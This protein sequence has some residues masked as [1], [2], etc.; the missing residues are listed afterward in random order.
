SGP[1][2][3]TR[4]ASRTG[5][6]KPSDRP[7]PRSI[8][9]GWR[10]ASI[11]ACP[12]TT[13]GRWWGSMIPPEPT[14]IREVAAAT[15]VMSTGGLLLATPGTAWCTATQKRCSPS[16]SARR[17]RS[18]VARSAAA[19]GSPARVRER[20]SSEIRIA[21]IVGSDGEQRRLAGAP[22]RP[23]RPRPGRQGAAVPPPAR[24]Q[25]VPGL[26]GPRRRPRR[27][28][29][30]P[31]RDA[32]ARVPGGAGGRG[33]AGG[34]VVPCPG[35]RGR[36]LVLRGAGVDRRAAQHRPG[37]ARPDRL[38]ATGGAGWS[39][40]RRRDVPPRP[41]HAAAALGAWLAGRSHHPPAEPGGRLT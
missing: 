9:P 20:S 38:G 16:D 21:L 5:W 33:R 24:A 39:P 19:G 28:W 36:R 37:G 3:V 15:A 8:R 2:D 25:L 31:G 12:A 27:A 30:G 32:G 7:R 35:R 29:R 10:A 11:L 6:V 1:Y 4:R 18:T 17:A 41:D 22:D 14:R 34:G 23:R 13:T 26:L 40:A